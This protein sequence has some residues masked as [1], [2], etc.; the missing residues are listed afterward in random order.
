MSSPESNV[1]E[2][3][4]ARSGFIFAAVGSAVGLGN[5]WRFPY[6]AYEN[7]GGAFLLPYLIALF[8]AGLPLLFLDYIVGHKYRRSAPL[9][10]KQI[11]PKAESLGWWQVMV[12][13]FIGAYYASV[14]AW[15]AS[16]VY[17][18]FGQKWQADPENFFT[19]QFLQSNT[20]QS[21]SSTGLSLD[22]IPH[23]FFPIVA[24]WLIVLTILLLG[25][26]RGIE[27]SN[28]IFIPL[29]IILFLILVITAV[30]LPGAMTGLDA[31]FTPNWHAMTNY[32]VWLAAYGHIFFSL[33]VGF[34]IMVTYA[35]Y[36]GKKVN[37][38]AS[39]L[40]VGLANSS[41]E[42]LAGIGVFAALG[43]MAEVQ[44][45]PVAEVVKGGIG[46]AFIVFPKLIS[47][48][49]ASGDWFGFLFFS[50]LVFAGITSLVSV[51]EVPISAIA[52]KTGCKRKTAVLSVG[53]GTAI[54]STLL[55]STASAMTLVDIM[56]HFV[57]NIGVVL[58]ALMSII[59]VGWIIRHKL[60]EFTQHVNAISSIKLGKIWQV[61]LMVVT[62]ISLIV[63]LG[64]TMSELFTDGYGDYSRAMVL[65]FGWGSV[66]C[67]LI[68]AILLPYLPQSKV[69][70]NDAELSRNTL[71][72]NRVNLKENHHE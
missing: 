69:Q 62:P 66:L 70:S 30:R 46:L 26:K 34:G 18:S 21:S 12:C 37:L 19:H 49:G 42:L 1:R 32:K 4:S 51:M 54:V 27:W 23:L 63:A 33:S 28:K 40:V 61:L 53:G 59:L 14:L 58:G 31:F 29:L 7:G 8:T 41:F 68:G 72:S 43:F 25:I 52:D 6:V 35:S 5:I 24:M 11:T 17:F 10:Y 56:D 71:E 15:A 50:C 16:Y 57:N 36:L 39:G 2:N 9:S 60:D 22:I 47:S 65:T 44:G 55:F 64:F 38:T 20:L 48:L 13:L 67:C 45:V 3:W